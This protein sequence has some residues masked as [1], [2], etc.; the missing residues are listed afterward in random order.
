MYIIVCNYTRFVRKSPLT[1]SFSVNI[2]RKSKPFVRPI[3]I[4]L[5]EY[6]FLLT[7][8]GGKDKRVVSKRIAFSTAKIHP[9]FDIQIIM[10]NN[11]VEKTGFF[12]LLRD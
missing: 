5:F 12:W 3:V 9:A 4:S 6:E 1:L 10:V 8:R 2:M 11:G 7:E